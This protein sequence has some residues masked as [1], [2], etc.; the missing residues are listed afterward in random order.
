MGW[1]VEL[2]DRLPA[3]ER[4]TDEEIQFVNTVRSFA[5][6]VAEV[7]KEAA[8]KLAALAKAHV[9]EAQQAPCLFKR[10]WAVGCCSL[11]AVP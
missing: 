8:G 7:E 2:W 1:G 9:A 11:L 6:K 3:I 10:A 5:A 4:R